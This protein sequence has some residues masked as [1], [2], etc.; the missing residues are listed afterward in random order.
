MMYSDF[1]VKILGV[2]LQNLTYITSVNTEYPTLAV[3][4]LKRFF[5]F[6]YFYFPTS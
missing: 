2:I 4:T 5:L 3:D 6:E 1:I